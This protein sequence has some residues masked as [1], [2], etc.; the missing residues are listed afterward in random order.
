MAIN[1]NREVFPP[2]ST[3]KP[4]VSVQPKFII[5]SLLIGAA[6][7]YLV[8]TSTQANAQYFLTVD[9]VVSRGQSFSG[10]TIRVSGAVI[11]DSIKYDNQTEVLSFDIANIPGD[12]QEVEEAGG[13]VVV[14]H[15]AVSDPSLNHL[16]INYKGIKPDLLKNEAQAILTGMLNTDGTFTATEVLLKCPSKYEEAIPAQAEK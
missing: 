10:K 2:V 1:G 9:E 16:K 13:L 4:A 5:G 3:Q 12:N 7:L 6:I 14:L 8:I 15:T 11:G